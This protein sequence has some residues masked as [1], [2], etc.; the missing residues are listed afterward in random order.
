M[1]IQAP[2]NM[3]FDLLLEHEVLIAPL[4]LDDQAYRELA[5]HPFSVIRHVNQDKVILWKKN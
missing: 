2:L 4:I 1:A 3:A 5:R